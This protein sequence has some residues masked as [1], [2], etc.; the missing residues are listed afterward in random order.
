MIQKKD[1][2]LIIGPSSSGKSTLLQK[3]ITKGLMKKNEI[4]FGYQYNIIRRYTKRIFHYNL[5]GNINNNNPDIRGDKLLKKIL[6]IKSLTVY[7]LFTEKKELEKRILNR[8]YTEYDIIKKKKAYKKEKNL[9]ILR[10][11]NYIELY[12]SLIRLLDKKEI[13]YKIIDTTKVKLKE[14]TH[15]EIY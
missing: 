14:I 2:I 9:N 13:K 11:C 10:G 12:Q 4:C 1:K 8:K 15:D 7:I 5:F 6:T 3:W